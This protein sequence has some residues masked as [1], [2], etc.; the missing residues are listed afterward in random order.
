MIYYV[1]REGAFTPCCG[2]GGGSSVPQDVIVSV[3]ENRKSDWPVINPEIAR[4]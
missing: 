1:G 2:G 4:G 3:L